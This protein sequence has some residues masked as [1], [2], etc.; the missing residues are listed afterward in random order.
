MQ[1]KEFVFSCFLL[2][3]LV[4]PKPALRLLP[5]QQGTKSITPAAAA[6]KQKKTEK[7]KRKHF[8]MQAKEF[9]FSCFL[10]FFLVFPKPALRLLHAQ[11]G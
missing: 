3:F 5:A 7:N 9:V 2:F 1:A 11:Q 6:K 8:A 10:L 4:F